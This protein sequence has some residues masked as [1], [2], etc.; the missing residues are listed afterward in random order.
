MHLFIALALCASLP[1][2]TRW[3]S[4]DESR[5]TPYRDWRD[6]A[7]AGPAWQARPVRTIAAGDG[8][9]DII[10]QSVL[11]DPLREQLDTLLADIAAEGWTAALIS[12]QGS[13]PE[14]LRA[15]LAAELDS[16]LVSAVLV[17]DLPVA[18]FQMVNDFQGIGAND[19]YEEFPCE[20]YFMDLNGT[21]LDT[22][23]RDGTRD[24]L[25]PGSDGIFDTH[26][27]HVAPE[28]GIS[29]MPIRSI[30][31]TDSLL[32]PYLERS[33][34]WR[35]GTVPSSHRALSY[36]DDDW[37]DWAQGWDGYHGL[38]YDGRDG[39]WDRETTRCSDYR[40]RI[41]D[42]PYESVL[43]CAHSW[44][45]GHTMYFA[46]RDSHDWFYA[47]E[48]PS[49]NPESRFWNLF[50]CSNARFT[51]WNFSAGRYVFSGEHGLGS[52]GSTKTGSMLEF[53]D[54]YRP[55]AEGA[56]F[57][58]AF[59]DWFAARA[60]GGF[61]PSE[62]SWFYGMALIGDGTLR[63]RGNSSGVARDPTVVPLDRAA[64]TILTAAALARLAGRV[65]YDVTGR[66]VNPARLTP[67]IYYLS[68]GNN[69][70]PR[71]IVVT[72]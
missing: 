21:W 63:P 30:S 72:R 3:V 65:L 9:I 12:A 15:F 48:I 46:R 59:R 69:L 32:R 24:S 66:T 51:E 36:I 22:L 34:G 53:Q 20:L 23:V 41:D 37:Y 17:G 5:P 29:R 56:D 18:W 35:A 25:V 70:P 14:S 8:R 55:L 28:I 62:R 4:P 50:A 54:W 39:V 1:P 38:V 60:A 6:A 27:G 19:G 57:N 68:A 61:N 44:P 11:V 52:I 10:I 40:R 7:E 13:S 64:P 67:G 16:G 45:G 42:L 26:F 58:T 43:L 71:R 31:G 49:V 2:V 47:R 33:H